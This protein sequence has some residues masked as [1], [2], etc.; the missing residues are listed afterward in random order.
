MIAATGVLHHPKY[1]EIAGPRLLRRCDVP[2]LALG[3]R[4]HDRRRAG[5]H[6]R[7]RLD[8]GADRLGRRRPGLRSSRSSSAPRSGSCRRRTRSTPN[9]EKAAF[10]ADPARL[11]ALHDAARGDVRDLRQRGD[12]LRFAGDQDDRGGVPR[13]SREQR[14]RSRAQR[15][16]P[17]R[18]P[19]RVQALDHLAR[20]LRCDP[21]AERRAGYG[22]D[23]A[24]SSRAGVRTV[25]G[26]LH[27][28]DVLVLATGFKADAF[29]RPMRVVGRAGHDPRRA[30]GRSG[31]TRTFRSRYPSSRTSSC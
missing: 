14:A 4:R 17:A 7:H 27:E 5:R 21:A 10:R 26:E 30:S 2:Q 12:R 13:Q 23:R 28:L 20:L 18:L 15:A 19:R 11:P 3:P 9:E 25:D 22:E 1:P 8:R 24:A 6:H 16:A 29:M 31:R